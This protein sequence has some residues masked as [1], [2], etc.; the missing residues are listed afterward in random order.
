MTVAVDS[1][2]EMGHVQNYTT[3]Y[4]QS[5][6]R[7]TVKLLFRD[8]ANYIAAW[9]SSIGYRPTISKVHYS[10]G[11]RVRVRVRFRVRSSDVPIRQWNSGPTRYCDSLPK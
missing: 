6:H 11:A 1:A 2:L 5:N 4:R 10:Y 9:R 8:I 3:I 7:D